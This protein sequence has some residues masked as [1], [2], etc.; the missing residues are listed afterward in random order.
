MRGGSGNIKDGKYIEK[1]IVLSAGWASSN[2]H[3]RLND[4]SFVKTMA[5]PQYYNILGQILQTYRALWN[6]VTLLFHR[7]VGVY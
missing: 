5:T 2:I 6:L 1:A 3:K 4:T 7:D